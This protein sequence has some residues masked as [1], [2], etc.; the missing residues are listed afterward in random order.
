[1]KLSFEKPPY[2]IP[3]IEVVVEGGKRINNRDN[4]H[5]HQIKCVVELA[6][7]KQNE[8]F[9]PSYATSSKKGKDIKTHS[10]YRYNECCEKMCS[11]II[12]LEDI[13]VTCGKT[14]VAEMQTP[15]SPYKTI[16]KS[17]VYAVFS[18]SVSGKDGTEEEDEDD[19]GE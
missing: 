5:E 19:S 18:Y 3:D 13:G 17:I 15:K 7:L 2:L 11:E 6:D 16:L 10:A 9:T 8:R 4:D 14:L 12:G 1:M